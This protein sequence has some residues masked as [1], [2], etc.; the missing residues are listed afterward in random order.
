MVDAVDDRHRDDDPACAEE[1]A[2]FGPANAVLKTRSAPSRV[3]SLGRKHTN[4]L[5][6]GFLSRI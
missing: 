3:P 5:A 1:I 4:A 2:L 6:S